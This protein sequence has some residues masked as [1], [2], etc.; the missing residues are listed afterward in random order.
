MSALIRRLRGVEDSW[1]PVDRALLAGILAGGATLVRPS[2]LLVAPGCALLYWVVAQRNRHGFYLAVT[3]CAGLAVA[4]APWTVRNY[5]VTGHVVPTT[6]WVGPSLYDG[7]NPQATGDSDMDFIEQD[8]VYQRMS[9]YDAD[10][11]YRRAA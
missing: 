8:G 4:L 2:W 1:A 6:L 3:M 11:Y 10:R 9:E 7:L 5:R